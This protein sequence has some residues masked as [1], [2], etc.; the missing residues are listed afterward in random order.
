MDVVASTDAAE[1]VRRRAVRRLQDADCAARATN[2]G[3]SSSSSSSGTLRFI[4]S[5]INARGQA[6]VC[7][8]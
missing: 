3:S 4:T 5:C 7:E 1:A 8:A 2:R 6:R